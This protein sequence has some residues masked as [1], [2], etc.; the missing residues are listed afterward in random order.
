MRN[1]KTNSSSTFKKKIPKCTTTF[2]AYSNLQQRYGEILSTRDE[3]IEFKANVK[4]EGFS[5]GDHYTTD[6]LITTAKG[7]QV[8]ETLSRNQLFKKSKIVLLDASREY[9]L[10]KGITDWGLVVNEE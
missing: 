5:L 10:S 3:V 7:L 8:R 9:W 2:F 4:L 1:G 6:F